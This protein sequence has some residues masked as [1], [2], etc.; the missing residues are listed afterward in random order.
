[1]WVQVQVFIYLFIYK[2]C[3]YGSH[4]AP[5]CR[6]LL[7]L[8]LPVYGQEVTVAFSISNQHFP[9]KWP[10]IHAADNA[11]SSSQSVPGSALAIPEPLLSFRSVGVVHTSNSMITLL[12]PCAT[13]SCI[14]LDSVSRE[15]LSIIPMLLDQLLFS[16]NFSAAVLGLATQN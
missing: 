13:H 10:K 6:H 4:F 9:T 3:S 8:T 12:I 5:S 15:Y 2:I 1:M 7:G 14:S 11:G 16:K